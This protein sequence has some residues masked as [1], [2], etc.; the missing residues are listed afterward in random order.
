MN[1]F[2]QIL[3]KTLKPIIED[4]VKDVID[5]EISSLNPKEKLIIKTKNQPVIKEIV[6]FITNES[7][8]INAIELKFSGRDEIDSFELYELEFKDKPIHNFIKGVN[9]EIP[10]FLENC[11]IIN[12]TSVDFRIYFDFKH[13]RGKFKSFSLANSRVDVEGIMKTMDKLKSHIIEFAPE[14]LV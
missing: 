14:F 13:K 11:D 9:E 4:I 6:T 7:V 1:I 12:F 5:D 10:T 3:H 2:K 8:K